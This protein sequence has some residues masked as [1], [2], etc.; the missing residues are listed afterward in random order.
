MP[1]GLQALLSSYNLNV[2]ECVMWVSEYWAY[3]CRNI[4]VSE[5]WGVGIVGSLE[6]DFNGRNIGL[7]EYWVQ[8]Q[9]YKKYVASHTVFEYCTTV[10]LMC[11]IHHLLDC[12]L[13]PTVGVKMYN[14][15]ICTTKHKV[16]CDNDI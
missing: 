9:H 12:V 11:C 15:C 2:F 10:F 5:Y 8:C 4:G 13:P 1:Q 6:T 7:S 3:S 14:Y 16:L